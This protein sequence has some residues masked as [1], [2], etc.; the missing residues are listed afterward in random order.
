MSGSLED[1][2]LTINCDVMQL[3]IGSKTEEARILL[4][5]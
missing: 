4:R 5:Y 2:N 3:C 1:Q